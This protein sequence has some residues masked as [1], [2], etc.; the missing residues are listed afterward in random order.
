MVGVD[1]SQTLGPDRVQVNSS[2]A[3][4]VLASPNV[5]SLLYPPLGE[6][7]FPSLEHSGGSPK[8]ACCGQ[9]P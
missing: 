2:I 8:D 1:V 3:V 6:A 4:E 7:L 5:D 9:C